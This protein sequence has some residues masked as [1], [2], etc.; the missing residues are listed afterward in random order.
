MPTALAAQGEVRLMHEHLMSWVS[1]F[2]AVAQI[3]MGAVLSYHTLHMWFDALFNRRD[4]ME[5]HVLYVMMPSIVALGFF[6]ALLG[7]GILC[8]QYKYREK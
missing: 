8:Y 3:A 5:P 2:I 6:P 4:L 1:T 7:I